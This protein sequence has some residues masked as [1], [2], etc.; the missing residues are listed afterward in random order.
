[1]TLSSCNHLLRVCIRQSLFNSKK[2][3]WQRF[4]SPPPLCHKRNNVVPTTKY[5]AEPYV[6]LVSSALHFCIFVASSASLRSS[7][8]R[9]TPLPPPELHPLHPLK[10]LPTPCSLHPHSST[11]CSRLAVSRTPMRRQRRSTDLFLPT[12]DHHLETRCGHQN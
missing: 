7:P 5:Q 10:E 6:A 12:T 4:S 3:E 8:S 11:S 1:M 9:D 2:Q